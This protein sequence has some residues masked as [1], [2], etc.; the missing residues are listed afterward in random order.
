[1]K[2]QSSPFGPGWVYVT[3]EMRS[4]AGVQRQHQLWRHRNTGKLKWYIL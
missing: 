2:K 4:R 1:M 3:V